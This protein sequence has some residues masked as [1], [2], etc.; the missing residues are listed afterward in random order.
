MSGLFFAPLTLTKNF[1]SVFASYILYS[2]QSQSFKIDLTD[3]TDLKSVIQNRLD[4]SRLFDLDF[5]SKL[6]YFKSTN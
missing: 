6:T 4:L 1:D 3:L 2:V 5:I